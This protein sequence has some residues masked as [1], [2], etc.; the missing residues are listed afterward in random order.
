MNFIA[1]FHRR[2]NKL[3]LDKDIILIQNPSSLPH[4]LQM[5]SQRPVYVGDDLDSY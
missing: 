4:S 5:I 3:K 1:P 2:E